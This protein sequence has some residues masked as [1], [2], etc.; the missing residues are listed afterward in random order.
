MVAQ[1]RDPRVGRPVAAHDALRR[2]AVA[3]ARRVKQALQIAG[4]G[5]DALIGRRCGC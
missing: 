3:S 2:D 1:R 4:G 5:V